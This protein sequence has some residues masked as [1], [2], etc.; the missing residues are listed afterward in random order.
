MKVK[1]HKPDLRE[2]ASIWRR[3]LYSRIVNT[4]IYEGLPAGLAEHEQTLRLFLFKYGKLA[5]YKL[6]DGT[7]TAQPFEYSKILDGWYVPTGGII[8][9]PYL[10]KGE[11]TK[12]FLLKDIP[13]LYNSTPD[14]YNYSRNSLVSDLVYKTSYQL[15]ES[16]ISYYCIQRNHRLIMVLTAEED[17]QRAEANAILEKMYMGEADITMSEDLIS[18]IKV[19]PISSTSSR[20]ILSEL[21]E[22]TQYILANFY[23]SFGI[24]SNYNLKREQLSANEIDVNEDAL[25][26]NIEDMLYARRQSLEKINAM[27]GTNISCRLNPDIYGD[28]SDGVSTTLPSEVNTNSQSENSEIPASANTDNVQN[29][30]S[31]YENVTNTQPEEGTNSQ[32][33][34]PAEIHIDT[35]V[36]ENVVTSDSDEDNSQSEKDEEENSQSEKDKEE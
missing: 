31:Q 22:F 21:V 9:N 26:L 18:H 35:V 7:F 28:E 5:I 3:I 24:N 19:N 13:I 10:P 27:W 17:K 8:T 32:S 12:N 4:I 23:H 25:S 34:N 15:A 33:E 16:D 2:N 20:A 1:T 6:R 11:Q 14:M 36:V 30:D 29:E